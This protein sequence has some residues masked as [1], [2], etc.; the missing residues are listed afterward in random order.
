MSFITHL[1][2][3]WNYEPIWKIVA[4]TSVPI[5]ALMCCHVK[6]KK[7]TIY[8]IS[9]VSVAGLSIGI[10][11]LTVLSRNLGSASEIDLVPFSFVVRGMVAPTVFREYWMNVYLF[12]PL[13]LMLPVI[14]K[15]RYWLVIMIGLVFSLLI[16]LIQFIFALGLCETD[17]AIANTLG[18]TIGVV[19]FRGAMEIKR[20]FGIE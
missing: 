18:C 16:E 17:D 20:R 6:L 12:I 1:I 3:L 9:V 8:V 10:L 5:I 15:D 14:L 2:H 19:I 7:K 13:G 4:I 11:Y